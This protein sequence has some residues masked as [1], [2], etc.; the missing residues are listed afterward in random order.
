MATLIVEHD[1]RR[2]AAVLNGRIVIGRRSNSHIVVQDRSVSRIHAWI[3][4][5]DGEYFIVDSGS[6]VGTLV[7]GKALHGRHSLADGDQVRVGPAMLTFRANGGLPADAEEIDLSPRPASAADGIFLDC[8]CGAP[9]WAPWDFAGRLGQCRYCGQMVELPPPM[10]NSPVADPSSDTMAP[11]LPAVAQS[12]KSRGIAMK[13]SI[14]DVPRTPPAPVAEAPARAV[15]EGLF[16]REPDLGAEPAWLGDGAPAVQPPPGAPPPV[17]KRAAKEVLCG[18]CQS[19]ID[20]DELMTR[21]PDCGVSFHPEC[22][23]ENRGCSSYGCKQV[24]VLDAEMA[25][26]EESAGTDDLEFE[27]V[28][29]RAASPEVVTAEAESGLAV[30]SKP[31]IEWDY[32]LLPLALVGA[33]LGLVAFGIPAALAGVATV[34]YRRRVRSIAHPRMLDASMIISLAAVVAG[35]VFSWYWWL[36]GPTVAGM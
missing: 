20:P 11:G 19:A 27:P 16:A 7:N 12:A 30:P 31:P 18:A 33:L 29:R 8:S 32:L 1:G 15:A 35:L 3:G 36:G 13:P 25:A 10:A 28:V 6:R 22:W 14:F 2:K 23:A 17:A 5:K 26:A 4:Q 24:G 34:V 21:C 9:L